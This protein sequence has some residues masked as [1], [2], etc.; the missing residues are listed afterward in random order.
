QKQ[1]YV[2]NEEQATIVRFIFDLFTK[3]SYKFRGING[4][5]TYLT[6]QA[7]PTARGAKI[8]Y[9]QVVRQILMN[10]AY[11]GVYYQNRY[12][13]EGNYVKKQAGEPYQTGRFRPKK[14]WLKTSIPAL[15]TK[16]Q[17]NLAQKRLMEVRRRYAGM[18]KH[19]YLLSGLVRCGRCNGLMIGR[20]HSSHG[21]A[22][23][24]YY[25]PKQSGSKGGCG[26]MMSERK[27]DQLIWSKMLDFLRPKNFVWFK[28]STQ[29]KEQLVFEVTSIEKR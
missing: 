20:K 22:Y 6:K 12:N 24:I 5:A 3:K 21:K 19:L 1:S 16:E 8:W 17:F 10:V 13:T 2:V 4:I 23:Y 14:E 18:T 11:T 27:L 29:E 26:R 25:C 7:I 28:D 15:I 9:R